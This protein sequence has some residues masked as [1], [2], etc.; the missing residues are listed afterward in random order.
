MDHSAGVSRAPPGRQGMLRQDPGCL[1]FFVNWVFSCVEFPRSTTAP[2][3]VLA[4][5]LWGEVRI[6]APFISFCSH[7][8]SPHVGKHAGRGGC[9]EVT[10][11]IGEGGH[12]Q[13]EKTPGQPLPARPCR[14]QVSEGRND[15]SANSCQ[16][17]CTAASSL[18]ARTGLIHHLLGMEQCSQAVKFLLIQHFPLYT[19]PFPS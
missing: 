1:P 18:A 15:T 19:S 17:A 13:S 3:A 6:L 9:A 7:G 2:G 10:K 4:A 11:H 14:R 12:T 8:D 16:L 5:L